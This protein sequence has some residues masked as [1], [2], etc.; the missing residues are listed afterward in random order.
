MKPYKG[1][2]VRIIETVWDWSLCDL[3]SLTQICYSTKIDFII[4]SHYLWETQLEILTVSVFNQ[5]KD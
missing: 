5:T 1:C 3:L 4:K 2:F